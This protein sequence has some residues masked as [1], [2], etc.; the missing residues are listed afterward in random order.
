MRRVLARRFAGMP[1]VQTSDATAEEMHLPPGV[2]GLV[3]ACTAY[4]WFDRPRFFRESARVLA[5]GGVLAI[6]RNRRK[7]HPLVDAFDRY[8]ETHS[9]ETSDL[10][11][12]DRGK[13][14]S[15]RELA[16]VEG[17]TGARSETWAWSVEMTPRQ[18]VDLYL[19]RST[20][21]GVVR[22]IGLRRV[23]ADLG[24]I[25]ATLAPGDL[26]FTA[27]W[28]TTAKWARKQ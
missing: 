19:T 3:V 15:V 17:F 21:W 5:P 6:L 12:R 28:E 7:R 2:A 16:Q 25:C 9:A 18:L 20:L 4:H 24:A 14:P 26:P 13:E 23:T 1:R 8:I 10:A 11:L 22:R 27:E